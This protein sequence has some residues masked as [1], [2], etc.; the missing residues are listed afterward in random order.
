MNQIQIFFKCVVFEFCHQP[1][2]GRRGVGGGEGGAGIFIKQGIMY[3]VIEK[4]TT[5]A[6]D[7]I[8][9]ISVVVTT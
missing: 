4:L 3:K 8:E 5:A 9:C 6:E 1:R 2:K 7:L